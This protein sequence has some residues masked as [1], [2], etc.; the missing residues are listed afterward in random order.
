MCGI[1]GFTGQHQAVDVLL[2][3]LQQLE[4]RGYDSA[5]VA[6]LHHDRLH[7]HKRSGRVADLAQLIN[8]SM[9]PG[10]TGIAHTRW[11]TH[12]A[13]TTINSHP[14][15]NASNT[16]AVV[17]NGV[18]EN[19]LTLRSMLEQQGFVFASQTDTE[20][21]AHL[22]D[23][24]TKHHDVVSVDV[25]MQALNQTLNMLQG[26][27]S[28]AA[29]HV[30]L[31]GHVFGAMFGSPLVVGLGVG[32]NF[33]ASDAVAI[34]KYTNN[35]V[36]LKDHDVVH[37]T[38][39]AYTIT[40]NNHQHVH[41]ITHIDA[42]A[43][44]SKDT[45]PH[46]MLKEI[47]EQPQSTTSTMHGR[48]CAQTATAN[49]GIC[50]PHDVD[51]LIL[52]GCGTALHAAMVGKYI[53]EHIA[54]T[55]VEVEHASEFRY[56]SAPRRQR[57]MVIA[58]SQSGETADT[59]AALKQAQAQGYPVASICNN[60]SSS[61]A[62]A[63]NNNI[64]MCI[65]PEIGV[66]ATKSFTSQCMILAMLALMIARNKH[67]THDQGMQMIHALQNIPA[68][69]QQALQQDACIQHIASKHASSQAMMFLG[70][71]FNYPVALE[72][73]LKLKEISYIHAMG[74]PSAELKHGVIALVEPSVPCVFVAPDDHVLEKNISNIQEVKARNGPVIGIGTQECQALH[75]LCDDVIMIPPCEDHLSPLITSIP[76]QLLAYHIA[77]ARGCD[78]DKPR[79][80]AKSVTVE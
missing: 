33:I 71:L 28:I 70:R 73:A 64:N 21:V 62:R 61:I 76:L 38:A 45:Y 41:E 31:Q 32:E 51:Q 26:T 56:R 40:N 4:Y 63:S 48:L 25:F 34:T 29:V 9:L 2:H 39:D 57:S 37:V 47:H 55:P 43:Q 54:K 14:H 6:T 58:L 68:L 46:F 18:I 3:G 30:D 1:I 77:V 15:C 44:A 79:N 11:A 72:G 5:G 17:H 67:M 74:Y 20:V 22:L 35:V 65:G 42:S 53:I 69:Q 52:V 78:V 24:H 7:V 80:L 19:H 12:G 27:Y 8:A 23:L 59:L 60:H 50:M 13:A 10:N 75:E 36:F 49:L 16:I 66:A